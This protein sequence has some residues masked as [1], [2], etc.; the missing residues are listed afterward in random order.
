MQLTTKHKCTA[1]I[2]Y[3]IVQ[4]FVWTGECCVLPRTCDDWILYIL[5]FMRSFLPS[6]LLIL[7]FIIIFSRVV[8]RDVAHRNSLANGEYIN[9]ITC[10]RQSPMPVCLFFVALLCCF[11]V[12]LWSSYYYW[13]WRRFHWQMRIFK[14][15]QQPRRRRRRKNGEREKR[16]NTRR[17]VEIW[18]AHKHQY[19]FIC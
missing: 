3:S 6:V 19:T 11:R 2:L 8:K 13:M 16:I 14:A 4:R 18:H 5:C 10:H 15:K 12:V 1:Y 17:I 7:F 9:G